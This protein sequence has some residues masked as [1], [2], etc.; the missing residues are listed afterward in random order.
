MSARPLFVGAVVS[1]GLLAGCGGGDSE[2]DAQ[3]VVKDFATA[4]NERDGKRFCTELTTRSYIERVTAAK[5]DAAVKRCEQ[6]IDSQRLQQTY[7]VLKFGKTKIDG[8]TATVTAELKIQGVRRP[9]A[10]RLRK[11]DGK[12]R[13]TSGATD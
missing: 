11:E 1:A 2:K 10:F 7:K 13:L 3:Q 9:Q 12:F 8:D 6:Q 5:G 4:V